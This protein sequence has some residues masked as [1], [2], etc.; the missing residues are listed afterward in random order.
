MTYTHNSHT[1]TVEWHRDDS[2]G[3]P[4]EEH[5]GHGIV[6]DWRNHRSKAPGERV[7]YQDR[8]SCRFYDVKGTLAIA[9]RDGWG[10]SDAE[11]EK[12]AKR[13]GRQPTAKEITAEAVERDFQYLRR[14]C[15][16]DW[17]WTGYNLTVTDADGRELP[18]L[19]DSLWGIDSDSMADYERDAVTTAKEAI[20]R[21][22]AC[23]MDAACRDIATV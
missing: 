16:D 5:D 15:S 7:L 19:S 20:D 3:A 9:R 10:L 2:L 14:W 22:I 11:K 4:W 18:G 1:I 12:L 23:S 21:E 6:S 17:Q 8:G 13:L